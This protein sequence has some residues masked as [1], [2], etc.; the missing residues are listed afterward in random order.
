MEN[1]ICIITLPFDNTK[2][3]PISNNNDKRGRNWSLRRLRGA[4]DQH[5]EIVRRPIVRIVLT[6]IHL[7]KNVGY[8]PKIKNTFSVSK[9]TYLS[10]QK[11]LFKYSK[12]LISEFILLPNLFYHHNTYLYNI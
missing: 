1:I 7:F 11:Y 10:I 6:I 4:L 8:H 3:I 9:N 12:I 5:P 2:Y